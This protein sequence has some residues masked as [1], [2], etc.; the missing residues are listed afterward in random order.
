MLAT[1]FILSV[2]TAFLNRARGLS[3]PHV[4]QEP[5]LGGGEEQAPL[6]QTVAGAAGTGACSSPTAEGT[7]PPPSQ[8]LKVLLEPQ[9]ATHNLQGL[10]PLLEG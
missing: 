9:V 10:T 8:G 1:A 3:Y 7:R 6:A 2:P 4:Q 5:Y